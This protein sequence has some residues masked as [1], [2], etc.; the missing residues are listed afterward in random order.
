MAYFPNGTSRE[1]LDAQCADCPL[2]YGW[3]DPRQGELFDP[4]RIPRPCPVLWVQLEYNYKQIINGNRKNDL[5]R[6]MTSLV[7]EEGVCQVRE[8]LVEI[9]NEQAS[10]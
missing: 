10:Q 6:A 3:N 9:R 5:A 1:V 8:Q 4:E 2:G 7:N